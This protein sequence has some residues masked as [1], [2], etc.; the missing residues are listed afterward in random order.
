MMTLKARSARVE[1]RALTVRWMAAAALGVLLLFSGAH[2]FALLL[3]G[4]L[5]AAGAALELAWRLPRLAPAFVPASFG[6]RIFDGVLLIGASLHPAVR[7][8]NL[9]LAAVPLVLIESHVHRNHRRM[10]LTIGIFGLAAGLVY[11]L[12][13]FSAGQFMLAASGLA[14]VSVLSIIVVAM[15]AREEKLARHDSRFGA[16]ISC[17]SALATSRDLA[18]MLFQTLKVAVN[19]VQG[20]AGYVMLVD[21]QHAGRLRSEVAFG[22]HGEFDFPESLAVGAGLSGYV[23]QMSQPIAIQGT[24]GRSLECDGIE[25]TA[26]AAIS[27]PLT[28]RVYIGT[29]DASREQTLGALTVLGGTGGAS[30]GA[31]DMELLR[32]IGSLMAVAVSNARME[33]RQRATF[34]RTLESLATALEA[35]DDYTRG[36]SQRVCELS[37]LIAEHLGFSEEAME[38]LRVGTI[39][40]DIGKIG[41]PDAILNKP[42]RLT[43]E[44][45]AIMKAHPVIGYD[46][47]RPLMLTEGVLLIIRNHHEKLDGS[48]YPDGLK[49]GELP[50][51]LR[52]VCVADAFDA[53]S[54]RRPYRGVMDIGH[55]LAELN[56]GAGVQFDPVVV[57]ALRDLLPTERVQACYRSCWGGE[58]AA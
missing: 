49:G 57:E 9:W 48:G 5:L 51:S 24:D 23:V 39:L 18:A 56:K 50:P 16:M 29:H 34:L 15:S 12:G 3:T 4:V 7:A 17:S 40:H 35:R 19:E 47:C 37:L 52:I 44:E 10:V 2:P 46:I 1:R 26:A 13:G 28:S 55:V 27:V 6:L 22:A 38:E 32:S 36:H 30:F 43:E 45:F 14:L 33:G 53:M 21:E 58:A 31:D 41:V 42:G 20:D 25:S 54:S 8:D 11:L